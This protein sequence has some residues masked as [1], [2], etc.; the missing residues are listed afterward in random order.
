MDLVR[1]TSF[2][3]ISSVGNACSA[4]KHQTYSWCGGWPTKKRTSRFVILDYVDLDKAQH[5]IE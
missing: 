3:K 2:Q 1:N 4:E 5:F